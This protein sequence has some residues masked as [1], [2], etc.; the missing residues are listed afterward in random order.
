MPRDE[1]IKNYAGA[2]NGVLQGK[3]ALS[4]LQVTQASIKE[5]LKTY[6][7]AK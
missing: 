2:V 5:T 6:G 7:V 1:M 3:D 4:S